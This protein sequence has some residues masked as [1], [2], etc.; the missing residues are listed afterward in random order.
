[1]TKSQRHKIKWMW[2]GIVEIEKW[3]GR[4]SFYE[5]RQLIN[6]LVSKYYSIE[7]SFL[8]AIIKKLIVDIKILKLQ[9]LSYI[10]I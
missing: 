7:S 9:K 1:M 5:K 6:P 2:D 10:A 4:I 8:M 3:L